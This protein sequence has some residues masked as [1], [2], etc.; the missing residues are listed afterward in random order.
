[1]SNRPVSPAA[2]QLEFTQAMTDFKIMFPDMDVDVIE[3]VLRANQGAV[4]STIDQLLAMSADNE[5]QQQQQQQGPAAAGGSASPP[6]A[7]QNNLPSYQQA[8][9]ST[10]TEQLST[11]LGSSTL[12]PGHPDLLL[13]DLDSLGAT[14]GM[15]A[16]GGGRPHEPGAPLHPRHNWRA[17]MLPRLPPDFLRLGR[18]QRQGHAYTHPERPVHSAAVRQIAMSQQMIQEKYTENQK[19]LGSLNSDGGQEMSQLLEDEKIAL[20]LQNEEFMRELKGNREF[21]SALEED[22][23]LPTADEPVDMATKRGALGMDDALFREKLKNM[24]KT[25]KQKFAKIANMFSRQRGAQ[26][27]LGHAPAPSKDNLLLN[28]E[29]LVDPREDSDTGESDEEK[30]S[31]TKVDIA[32]KKAYKT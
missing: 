23:P 6:P 30:H 28:A 4:D 25:S 8:V 16:G 32:A 26:K 11:M 14:G 17:R 29:P 5:S 12:E 13:S 31:T 18:S 3:A 1:M 15:A 24:G 7:Y 21:M 2:T 10:P 27:L 19:R 20:M 9:N 22:H